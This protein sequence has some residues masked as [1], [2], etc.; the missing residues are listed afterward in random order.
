MSIIVNA[1]FDLRALLAKMKCAKKS[2]DRLMAVWDIEIKAVEDAISVID[3]I[4]AQRSPQ[5]SA[6]E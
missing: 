4:R 6:S 3:A 2:D 1:P 5:E